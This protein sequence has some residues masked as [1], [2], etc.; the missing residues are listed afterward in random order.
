MASVNM[1]KYEK[2]TLE[3]EAGHELFREGDGAD[4]MYVVQHG[5]LDI[6]INGTVVETVGEGGVVGEMALVDQSPRSATVVAKMDCMLVP[7]DESDFKTHVHTTPFFA[8][9]VMRVMVS[10]LRQMNELIGH[11]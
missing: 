2:N 3:I 8:L 4:L 6:L 11:L 1:F 9:Q 7:F 10:R 5:E